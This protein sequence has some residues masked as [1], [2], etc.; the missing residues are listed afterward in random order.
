MPTWNF[1]FTFKGCTSRWSP[2]FLVPEWTP[3]SVVAF[4]F[5]KEFAWDLLLVHTCTS[6]PVFTYHLLFLYPFLSS[7]CL[8]GLGVGLTGVAS[9]VSPTAPDG[10]GFGFFGSLGAGVALAL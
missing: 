9:S 4:P 3:F 7:G 10:L 6:A 8:F 2:Q 5:C 1:P